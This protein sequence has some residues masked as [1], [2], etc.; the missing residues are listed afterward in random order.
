MK[1]LV[2]FGLVG[3]FLMSSAGCAFKNPNVDLLPPTESSNDEDTG[4]HTP[5]TE[6]S[7]I[8]AVSPTDKS[9]ITLAN[10]RISAWSSS[11]DFNKTDSLEHC[12]GEDLYLPEPVTFEWSCNEDA[13]YYHV[14]ISKNSNFE[15]HDSY[16]VNDT[17]LTLP[18]L[19]TGTE[20]YW[21]V[22]AFSGA[23]V[24]SQSAT[25]TFKTEKHPRCIS[26]DGVSNTRD[27]GGIDCGNGIQIKQ[28][29]VYRGARLN[30]ITDTGKDVFINELGIRTDLDLRSSSE[31]GNATHSPV[32][33]SLNY[34]Q[35]SGRYYN[36]NETGIFSK[37]GMATIAEEIKVFANADNYPI[38]FHCQVG[39]DRTG[40]LALILEGL[41]GA[42]QNDIMKDY[43][44][45]YFS[46]IGSP[47]N[48]DELN[49]LRTQ[50]INTYNRILMRYPGKTFA[51]KV[52]NYLISAGVTQEE[53]ESIRSIMLEE[54]Q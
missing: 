39:R 51:Q 12:L 23:D 35:I 46:Q 5:I 7:T 17:C 18:T 54:V 28:G 19:Y 9:S 30:Y 13:D 37:E 38:Y 34:Y 36:S 26:I 16:L 43:E 1:K 2:I 25:F 33:D 21:K 29:L 14:Y 10:A 41:L 27:I 22:Y 31:A 40:T 11:Y 45:S 44:L 47:T 53:I 42:S 8:S 4:M 15:D 3:I 50:I 24:L 48:Q 20:Y 32:D 49:A 52:E 6:E